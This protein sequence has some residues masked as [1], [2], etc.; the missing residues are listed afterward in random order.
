MRLHYFKVRIVGPWNSFPDEVV[1]APS[2]KSL[3]DILDKH[4]GNQKL[5]Y[6]YEAALY[7]CHNAKEVNISSKSDDDLDTQD[8]NDQ[9][10]VSTKVNLSISTSF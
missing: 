9:R 1:H 3:E 4:W 10:P 7:L 8:Y 5:V 2:V 6:N